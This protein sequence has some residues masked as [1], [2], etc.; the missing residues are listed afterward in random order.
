V[1]WWDGTRWQ[2]DVPDGG[3]AP[4]TILPFVMQPEGAGHLFGFTTVKDAPFPEHYEPY[5]S[6]VPNLLSSC[7]VN[8]CVWRIDKANPEGSP[9]AL[10]DAPDRA[11]YPHVCSTWRLTEYL[12]SMSRNVV[13][14]AQLLPQM[15]VEMSKEL[16]QEL[17]IRDGE[18]VAVA[19]KRGRVVCRALVTPRVWPLTVNGEK[20]HVVGM[21]WHWGYKG[22]ITGDIANNATPDIGDPN[23]Q[24]QESKAFLVRVEK[25]TQEDLARHETILAAAEWPKKPRLRGIGRG[26]KSVKEDVVG[27]TVFEALPRVQSPK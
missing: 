21:P 5:E 7:Q 1:I 3:G 13:W 4:G 23:T 26:E 16:A 22:F 9:L 18:I 14:L 8:P 15:F 19:S 20:L 6:R 2:G 17:G 11:E 12:T 25:A 27:G 10:F 24:I